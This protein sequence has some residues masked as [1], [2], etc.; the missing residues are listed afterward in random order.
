MFPP[1]RLQ[2]LQQWELSNHQPIIALAQLA[3]SLYYFNQTIY[4]PP[5]GFVARPPCV[6]LNLIGSDFQLS[7]GRE[8]EKS[9]EQLTGGKEPKKILAFLYFS[10][11]I[12]IILVAIN[13]LWRYYLLFDA[14]YTQVN[15]LLTGITLENHLL[16][17]PKRREKMT[18]IFP[19]LYQYKD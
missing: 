10:L 5:T 13:H 4:P 1:P 15:I 3:L 14:T 18:R 2:L 16:H 11:L 19:Y 8:R 12:L 6:S 17:K 9:N 7:W